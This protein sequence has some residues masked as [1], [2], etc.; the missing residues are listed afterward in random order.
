ME[1]ISA[2]ELIAIITAAGAVVTAV[3]WAIR[4]K[5]GKNG[6]LDNK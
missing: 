3:I 2:V 5:N 1:T 4:R 6:Q